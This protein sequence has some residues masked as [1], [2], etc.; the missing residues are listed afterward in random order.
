M[1]VSDYGPTFGVVVSAREV[2]DWNARWPCS[3]LDGSQ[4]FVFDKATGDLVEHQGY[5]ENGGGEGLALSQDAQR[6]G[7]RVLGIVRA[8]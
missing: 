1:K 4:A 5:Y 3:T 8:A 6:H 7:E 2:R